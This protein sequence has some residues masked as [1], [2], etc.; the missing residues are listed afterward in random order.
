[1]EDCKIEDVYIKFKNVEIIDSINLTDFKNKFEEYEYK[2]KDFKIFCK[3]CNS[4]VK[5][6]LN[7]SERKDHFSHI[8]YIKPIDVEKDS[9]IH[10]EGILKL[11]Q[12]LSSGNAIKIERKCNICDL[13]T[14]RFEYKFDENIDNIVIDD[15]ENLE[16]IGERFDIFIYRNNSPL[17]GIEV[18]HTHRTYKRKFTPWFEI[19]TEDIFLLENKSNSLKCVR[20]YSKDCNKLISNQESFTESQKKIYEKIKDIYYSV[21]IN[22][23]LNIGGRG[24]SGKSYLINAI[25]D[26]F[27]H[28]KINYN[29][30][31]PTG[32]SALLIEGSTYHS[33]YQIPR[34]IEDINIHN[35]IEQKLKQKEYLPY[36][37]NIISL[38][39]V[40]FDESSM[41][42]SKDFDYL[43][44]LFR[45]IRKNDNFFGGVF[46]ILSGDPFQIEPVED[47]PLWNTEKFKKFFNNCEFLSGNYRQKEDLEFQNILE[48]IR[49][50]YFYNEKNDTKE[51]LYKIKHLKSFLESKKISNENIINLY[52][53]YKHNITKIVYTNDKCN[54]INSIE[55]EKLEGK[56]YEYQKV[57]KYKSKNIKDLDFKEYIADEKNYSDK[58]FEDFDVIS[59]EKFKKGC[60]V[61]F[62]KNN[63]KLGYRNG[64]TGIIKKLNSG[65]LTVESI[66]KEN[67]FDVRKEI[68]VGYETIRSDC[69]KYIIDFVPLRLCYSMTAHKSQGQTINCLE[70]DLPNIESLNLLYTSLSRVKSSETLFIRNYP[71]KQIDIDIKNLENKINYS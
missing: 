56:E 65:S 63:N 44:L 49:S 15:N 30:V 35:Y 52:Q 41:I 58:F 14:Q 61:M 5:V 70:I 60:R 51:D 45:K 71:E 34:D 1:M 57:K 18:Y 40:I 36:T 43:D 64:L 54:K 46:I 38:E 25:K 27:D 11:K 28:N 24:G 68:E 37:L 4:K 31:T 21:D 12:F 13:Y 6:I 47:K 10:T 19:K 29:L 22:K 32:I 8:N 66:I 17:F 69:K 3:K 7:S 62:V 50:N 23:T 42:K 39:V 53:K 16:K 48:I 67:G 9:S 33:K 59:D 26:Y 20:K 2:N 55:F